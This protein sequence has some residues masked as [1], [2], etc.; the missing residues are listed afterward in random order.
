MTSVL[1]GAYQKS[2]YFYKLYQTNFRLCIGF[3][4]LLRQ[5]CHENYVLY[6]LVVPVKWISHVIFSFNWRQLVKTFHLYKIESLSISIFAYLID[7]RHNDEW[8]VKEIW[9]G[10]SQSNLFFADWIHLLCYVV[11]LPKIRKPIFSA[12]FQYYTFFLHNEVSK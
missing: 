10:A 2:S 8:L 5:S 6:Y 7:L 1:N 4:L 11:F 3:K 12:I 9:Y